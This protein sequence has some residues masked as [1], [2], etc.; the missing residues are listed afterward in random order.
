MPS[1][2]PSITDGPFPIVGIGASAGG[3]EALEAILFG[4]AV[5]LDLSQLGVETLCSL[6]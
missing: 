2:D 3:L 5:I 4:L 1:V 6:L